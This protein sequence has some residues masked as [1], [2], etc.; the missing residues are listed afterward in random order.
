M[1]SSRESEP[2]MRARHASNDTRTLTPY[3][4]DAGS[5]VNEL[6]VFETRDLP[7][8]RFPVRIRPDVSRKNNRPRRRCDDSLT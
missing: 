3:L 4:Q 1:G 8:A 7:A 5:S 2:V 6:G